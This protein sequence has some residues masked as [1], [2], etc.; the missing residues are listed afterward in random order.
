M[1]QDPVDRAKRA[2]NDVDFV[3]YFVFRNNLGLCCALSDEN[4]LPV[5]NYVCKVS[6][7][8]IPRFHPPFS[9]IHFQDSL[10]ED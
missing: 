1:Q 2:G 9:F 5:E 3:R 6:K 4:R 8:L 10:R 7:A